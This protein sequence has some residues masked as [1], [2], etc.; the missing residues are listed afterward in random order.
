MQGSTTSPHKSGT[1][2][3]KGINVNVRCNQ[4]VVTLNLLSQEPWYFL[5]IFNQLQSTCVYWCCSGLCWISLHIWD[6]SE[7][8]RLSTLHIN[9]QTHKPAWNLHSK[10]MCV[11][12]EWAEHLTGEYRLESWSHR[13]ASICWNQEL[14][15]PNSDAY[16]NN[17]L[18]IADI[19]RLKCITL[20]NTGCQGSKWFEA[21]QGT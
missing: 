7:E 15:A 10:W 13:S 4:V 12:I 20:G 14:S 5:L 6:N 21:F 11:T 1:G 2:S 9:T 16:I 17:V 3:E 18:A 8:I 19:S